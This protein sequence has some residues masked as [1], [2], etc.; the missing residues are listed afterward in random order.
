[1]VGLG[2]HEY[3]HYNQPFKPK[4]SNYGNDS[5]GNY[6]SL[7]FCRYVP[8]PSFINIYIYIKGECGVPYHNRFHMPSPTSANNKADDETKL[9]PI[10]INNNNDKNNNNHSMPI[11]DSW[12]YSFD[13]GNAHF[14]VISTEHDFLP[15][16]TIKVYLSIYLPT[17]FFLSIDI[18]QSKHMYVCFHS[19]W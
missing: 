12:W 13:Y 1:M 3:D 15:G 14:I 9:P 11:D 5:N 16:R 4:W 6:I 17:F 10:I 8:Q 7:V 18:V 2:N 19:W